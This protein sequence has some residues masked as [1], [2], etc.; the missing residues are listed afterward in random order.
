MMAWTGR[1][2]K[3]NSMTVTDFTAR[4]YKAFSTETPQK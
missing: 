1:E 3:I 2:D 4:H